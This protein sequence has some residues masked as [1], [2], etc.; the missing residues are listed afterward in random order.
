MFWPLPAVSWSSRAQL[1]QPP[2]ALSLPIENEDLSRGKNQKDQRTYI[3]HFA[4]T[5]KMLEKNIILPWMLRQCQDVRLWVGVCIRISRCHGWAAAQLWWPM[6]KG[7]GSVRGGGVLRAPAGNSFWGRHLPV[8][9]TYR[10][11]VLIYKKGTCQGLGIL[12]T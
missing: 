10:F 6:G 2:S 8:L 7:S 5:E 3:A 9:R 12:S 11:N 4:S 1:S